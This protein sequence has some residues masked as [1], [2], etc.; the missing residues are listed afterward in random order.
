MNGGEEVNIMN[1]SE[2]FFKGTKEA[3][4]NNKHIYYFYGRNNVILFY[5]H[6][7]YMCIFAAQRKSI[8]VS[9]VDLAKMKNQK[10]TYCIS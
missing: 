5:M 8:F 7:V 6:H 4:K 3:P 9:R 2:I 1:Y 10:S